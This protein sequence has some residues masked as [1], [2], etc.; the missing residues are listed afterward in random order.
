MVGGIA[1]LHHTKNTPTVPGVFISEVSN[2]FVGDDSI[3][4]D[5]PTPRGAQDK[6]LLAP[7][8]AAFMR[9][10]RILS[11]APPRGT[12]PLPFR[13]VS[14]RTAQARYVFS[15]A[16]IFNLP[17]RR[18]VISC[19][20]EK[21]CFER[22]TA[23]SLLLKKGGGPGRGGAFYQFTLSPTLSPLVPRGEREQNPACAL[24]AEHNWL[25]TCDTG[26]CKSALRARRAG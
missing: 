1:S 10:R 7:R 4:L 20:R 19:V 14:C 12:C 16:Q 11:C 18:F 2:H 22:A 17:Y 21:I 25:K 9:Q 24:R 3:T 5:S 6:F 26:D 13:A 8:S 15:V 23:L